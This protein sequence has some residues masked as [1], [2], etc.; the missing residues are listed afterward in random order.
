LN[1]GIR[2]FWKDSGAYEVV[3]VLATA[4]DLDQFMTD[5]AAD[6]LIRYDWVQ[7]P[8]FDAQ[9]TNGQTVPQGVLDVM[10]DHVT[11]DEDGNVISTTPPDFD[12]P[13]WG[14]VFLGQSTRIF[15]G[16]FLPADFNEDFL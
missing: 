4:D 11:Y 15:A 9:E 6:V 14:H 7:G 8:G 1:Q 10:R 16:D 5:H 2:G 3:N 13:N 12:T